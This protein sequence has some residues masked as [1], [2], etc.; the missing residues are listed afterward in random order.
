MVRQRRSGAAAAAPAYGALL[1]PLYD[2][3]TLSYPRV[4]FP[5]AAGH[6]HSRGRTCSWGAWWSV[7]AMS[8][9]GGVRCRGGRVVVEVAVAPGLSSEQHRAVRTAAAEL[10]EFLDRQLELTINGGEERG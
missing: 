10:A 2:E 7:T 1:L 4:N 6:P 3:V 5:R 8:A 9:S